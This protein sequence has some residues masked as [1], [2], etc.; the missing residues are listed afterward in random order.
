LGDKT[1]EIG[2]TVIYKNKEY[3]IVW[4]YNNGFYEIREKGSNYNIELVH[5]SNFK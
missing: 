1:L 5:S 2:L 3:V 4:V